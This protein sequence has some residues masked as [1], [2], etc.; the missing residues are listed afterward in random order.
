MTAIGVRM[1][2]R[3]PQTSSTR[4]TSATTHLSH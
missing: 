1:W 3:S 2:K 4:S